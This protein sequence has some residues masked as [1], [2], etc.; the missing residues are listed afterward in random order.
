[1][2]VKTKWD[3]TLVGLLTI[4][5]RAEWT[6]GEL[7]KQITRL[8]PGR[9]RKPF[10]VVFDL[11]EEM[12]IPD[13]LLGNMIQRTPVSLPPNLL[14][15]VFATESVFVRHYVQEVVRRRRWSAGIVVF[16]ER[17]D[18]A[19]LAAS[20]YLLVKNGHRRRA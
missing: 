15:V 17:P 5:I 19:R 2:P 12:P 7:E 8:P 9:M 10:V 14:C 4:Q 18:L 13:D 1:M 6:W 16:V 3:H 11:L 20:Q